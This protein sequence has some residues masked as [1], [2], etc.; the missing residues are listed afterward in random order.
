VKTV[1]RVIA[2]IVT[3]P[4]WLIGG[5]LLIIISGLPLIILMNT[6]MAILDFALTGKWEWE[7]L[8]RG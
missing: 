8:E 1:L 6:L 3:A 7:P 4:I 2:A 5:L